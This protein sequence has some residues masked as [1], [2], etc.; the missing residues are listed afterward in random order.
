MSALWFVT[1]PA[2]E[3]VHAIPLDREGRVILVRL[4]Y[5][6]GWRLPGGGVGPREDRAAAILRELREEIGMTG[7][8]PLTPV[9]DFE[10]R[11]DFRRD[12]AT[13][14]VVEGVRHRFAP[15]LEVADARAFPPDELPEDLP[16]ITR[17]LLALW[18]GA[19]RTSGPT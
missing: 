2:S 6:A 3:G 10:H 9:G 16:P 15:S 5:A 17:Q 4:S 12:S 7:H 13:L 1:R 19:P 18:R 14:F 11:P 8:G